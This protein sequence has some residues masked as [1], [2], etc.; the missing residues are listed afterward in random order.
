MDAADGEKSYRHKKIGGQNICDGKVEKCE[1]TCFKTAGVNG[2]LDIYWDITKS[3]N[4]TTFW[5]MNGE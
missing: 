3:S 1:K 2:V 5:G 4:F